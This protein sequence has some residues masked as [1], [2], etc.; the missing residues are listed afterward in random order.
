LIFLAIFSRIHLTQRIAASYFL[1]LAENRG[2]GSA[3]KF[4]SERSAAQHLKWSAIFGLFFAFLQSAKKKDFPANFCK[5]KRFSNSQ[6]LKISL[7][8]QQGASLL[9]S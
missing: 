7:C 8:R 3:S 2:C 9:T 5:T 6:K 4:V 1:S